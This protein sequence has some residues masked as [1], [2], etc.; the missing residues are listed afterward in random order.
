MFLTGSVQKSSIIYS[1]ILSIIVR[2]NCIF[3]I[4]LPKGDT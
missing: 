2:Y 1:E 4:A 3:K